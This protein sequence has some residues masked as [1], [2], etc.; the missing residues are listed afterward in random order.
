M[1]EGELPVMRELQQGELGLGELLR[2][3]RER[4]GLSYV[5]LEAMTRI[6]RT[7]LKALEEEKFE[8][9]PPP[10]FVKGYLKILAQALDIEEGSLLHIYAQISQPPPQAEFAKVPIEPAT[11]PSPWRRVVVLATL[12]LLV[13]LS[14]VGYYALTELRQFLAPQPQVETTYIQPEPSQEAFGGDQGAIQESPPPKAPPAQSGVRVVLKASGRSWVRVI[15]DREKV[16]EGFLKSG[17]MGSWEASEEITIRVGNAGG[18]AVS[19]NG[20]TFTPM[21]KP[22]QVVEQTFTSSP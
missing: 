21:G 8:L 16:F 19:V 2:R 9:L 13:V 4:K 10:I 1:T 11:P 7:Y 12:F 18:V 22:G 20:S 6:R 15:A 14:A 17:E 5:D 3:A